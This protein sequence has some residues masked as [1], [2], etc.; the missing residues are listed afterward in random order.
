MPYEDTSRLLTSL[1]FYITDIF[2]PDDV[3]LKAWEWFFKKNFFFY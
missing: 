3:V 2:K 1:H